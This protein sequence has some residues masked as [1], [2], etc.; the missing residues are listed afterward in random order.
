MNTT[1]RFDL[2]DIVHTLRKRFKF[3]VV[4]TLIATAIAA[5][6]HFIRHKHYKGIAEFFVSNPFYA[7]RVNIFGG[8]SGKLDYYGDE[9]DIDKVIAIATSDTVVLKVLKDAGLDTEY[10]YNYVD[11][12]DREQLKKKFL[13]SYDV[14]RTENNMIQLTYVDILPER[15][16]RVANLAMKAIES[17]YRD[18]YNSRRDNAANALRRKIQTQDSIINVLTDTLARLRDESGIYD[19]LSP[20]RENLVNGAIKGNGK[21]IGRNME[22]IQNYESIKDITVSDRAKNYSLLGQYTTGTQP[23]EMPLF[24]V[25]TTAKQPQDPSDPTLAVKLMVGFFLGLFFSSLFVLIITYYRQLIA[26]ER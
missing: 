2:V 10:H 24:H 26:V 18:F 1:P 14:K 7:D 15:A 3:I 20:N 8:L 12:Y 5:V 9:D 22:M 4:V 25:V 21:N 11:T 19:I 16:S 17:T 23:D 13:G 6:F